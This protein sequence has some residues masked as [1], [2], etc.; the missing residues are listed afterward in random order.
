MGTIFAPTYTTLNIG[1]A[2]IKLYPEIKNW[3][4]MT[5]KYVFMEDWKQFLGKCQLLLDADK[6]TLLLETLN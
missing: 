4:N 1:Y 6:P 2:E 5:T 3:F